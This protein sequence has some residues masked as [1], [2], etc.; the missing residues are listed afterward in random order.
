LTKNETILPK[1]IRKVEK[2]IKTI[3][4]KAITWKNDLDAFITRKH[5]ELLN[6]QGIS[7]NQYRKLTPEE[8]ERKE[9]KG[10]ADDEEVEELMEGFEIW[11]NLFD[12]LEKKYLQVLFYQKRINKNPE[13]QKYLNMLKNLRI[14]LNLV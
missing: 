6:K 13:N 9:L 14:E 8:K 3:N 10:F 5:Q 11:D 12:K 1:E 7:V 2:L 4:K